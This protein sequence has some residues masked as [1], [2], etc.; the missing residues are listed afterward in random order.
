MWCDHACRGT[1]QG[2]GDI[3]QLVEQVGVPR[4]SGQ[5]IAWLKSRLGLDGL[6]PGRIRKMQA[7]AAEQRE[8][9]RATP[10]SNAKP[11]AAPRSAC[12]SA[13]QAD[14][15]HAGR[16]R[17]C[18]A[19]ASISTASAGCRAA[20]RSIRSSIARKPGASCRRWWRRSSTSPGHIATHR[21]WL[22]PERPRRLD[23]GGPRGA[24]EGARPLHRRVH[25]AVEG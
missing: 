12:G 25:P 24:E 10:T 17:I 3:I 4:R 9:S 8:A 11:S 5:A 21:T 13:G 15:G 6:D 19:A 20:W 7:E 22:A 14:R 18:A 2:G 23:Q 1:P 16:A